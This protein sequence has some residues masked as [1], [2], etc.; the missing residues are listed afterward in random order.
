MRKDLRFPTV[1]CA[2]AKL[3]CSGPH[4][5]VAA[6]YSNSRGKIAIAGFLRKRDFSQVRPFARFGADY[7]AAVPAAQEA[8]A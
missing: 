6:D 2:S 4:A 1:L 8:A 3:H 5:K 7:G